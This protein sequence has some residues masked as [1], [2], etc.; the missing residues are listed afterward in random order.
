M[1]LIGTEVV[2]G[3]CWKWGSEDGGE[4]SVG[5][6]IK[7]TNQTVMVKWK[8]NISNMYR[9]GSENNYDLRIF[10]N[11]NIGIEHE[12]IFCNACKGNNII[13]GLRYQCQ[14]CSIID[15]CAKCYHG[16][17][18]SLKHYFIMYEKPGSTGILM[19]NRIREKQTNPYTENVYYKRHLPI[20]GKPTYQ[21]NISKKRDNIFLIDDEKT[22][23]KIPP[24]SN[25]C[26]TCSKPAWRNVTF[27]PCKHK[28]LCLSC[29][30]NS[31]KCF[32]CR[33]DIESRMTPDGET[34]SSETFRKEMRIQ[35]VLQHLTNTHC[36]N[37]CLT[38]KPDITF[39]CGH[40]ACSNCTQQLQNCHI[41]NQNISS[42]L[43]IFN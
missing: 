14:Q 1:I 10:N 13:D 23:W 21:I 16:D 27:M 9:V 24:S 40:N 33:T 5:T 22:E 25:T 35:A 38:N 36:C 31:K 3:P 15:L 4:G 8:N 6:I 34:I 37:I 26:L 12:N 2:R 18:H 11:A 30:L 43:Q 28:L 7:V 41:C 39:S 19:P 42:K 32:M 20:L 17:K 29:S